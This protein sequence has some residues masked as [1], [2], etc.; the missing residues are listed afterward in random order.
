MLKQLKGILSDRVELEEEANETQAGLF[1]KI[2]EILG[3]ISKKTM[4]LIGRDTRYTILSDPILKLNEKDKKMVIKGQAGISFE[5]LYEKHKQLTEFIDQARKTV[6]S[7]DTRLQTSAKSE[8]D[9][10]KHNMEEVIKNQINNRASVRDRIHKCNLLRLQE[11]SQN[12]SKSESI[13]SSI[14]NDNVKQVYRENLSQRIASILEDNTK[15]INFQS[16]NINLQLLND[17][18]NENI[19]KYISRTH[20]TESLWSSD[21]LTENGIGY[22]YNNFLEDYNAYQELKVF[23]DNKDNE[24]ALL[25]KYNISYHPS[26]FR[27]IEELNSLIPSEISSLKDLDNSWHTWGENRIKYKIQNI[28]TSR[29][30][31]QIETIKWFENTVSNLL[32]ERQRIYI[33]NLYLDKLHKTISKENLISKIQDIN[34][35]IKKLERYMGEDTESSFF[36]NVKYSFENFCIEELLE[37]NQNAIDLE[38]KL[39][40]ELE[41]IDATMRITVNFNYKK[42]ANIVGSGSLKTYHDLEEKHRSEDYNEKRS[43]HDQSLGYE[44]DRFIVGALSSDN[45]VDEILGPCPFYGHG[46]IELDFDKIKDKIAYFEGDSLFT[47]P[48]GRLKRLPPL[49]SWLM[50]KG[51]NLDSRKLDLQGAK[52]T[53]AIMNLWMYNHKFTSIHGLY[54]ET[55]IL[56]P[57]NVSDFKRVTYAISYDDYQKKDRMKF[58]KRKALERHDNFD[59]E[60]LDYNPEI[61][62]TME[63]SWVKGDRHHQLVNDKGF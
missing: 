17:Y 13:I 11:L 16:I 63:D 26:Y 27:G 35:L 33:A 39:L 10:W 40:K 7:L 61:V 2:R 6:D 38:Q 43:K 57:V 41:K 23:I 22:N 55:H 24:E 30:N 12:I 60:I 51:D 36:D 37:N 15:Y 45:G 46:V 3:E 49:P 44:S 1:V 9:K 29:P 34:K 14:S 53:K 50:R 19:Y 32:P 28:K 59:L 20:D 31:N 56:Q 25:K 52:F 48:S 47:M 54:V 42:I 58:L 62:K 8:I 18:N 4:K 5:E 21:R